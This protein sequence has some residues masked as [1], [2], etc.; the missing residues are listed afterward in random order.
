MPVYFKD[1][2]KHTLTRIILI[3][4]LVFQSHENI[5][6]QQ[7]SRIGIN[8]TTNILSYSY[9]KPE[10]GLVFERQ[11][12]AHSGIE[13]NL[14][15]RTFAREFYTGSGGGSSVY[16]LVNERYITIP[17][18]YK[19]YT[20]IVNASLGVSYDYYLGWKEQY[21]SQG[22]VSYWPGADYYIGAIGKISRQFALG[23]KFVL[24]PEVKF[25]IT[26]VPY[27]KYYFG[28]GLVGKFDL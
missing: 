28:I 22:L 6:A 24:E 12:T 11:F 16:H 4:L 2:A 18:T 26:L 3:I 21:L 19:Y 8:I 23:E 17:V 20:K 27:D 13:A 1:M 10:I 14:N 7:K 5:A 9:V 15:F 25:N